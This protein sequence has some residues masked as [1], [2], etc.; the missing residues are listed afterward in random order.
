M[1]NPRDDYR[2]TIIGAQPGDSVSEESDGDSGVCGTILMGLS[3]VLIIFTLPFSLCVC[4][5]VV[6]EYERAVIF[7]LGRLMSGGAKGP[8]IFFILPCI[9]AYARVDLRTR[10][11]DVP[12]QEVLTK[13][14]VTVSVD[15][16]VYYRVSNATI[17]VANVEN[18]HHST[19]LLAQ[20]TLRNT[21]GMRPLHE[22]LSDRD[23]ISSSMQI[24]LDGATDAWGIKVER[25][26]IK[27]VRLPVQLQRAMAAEAEAAREARAKVIAAEG[28]QRASRALREAAEVIGDSPAALQ[29]RY[30]QT[31]NTISAEKNSTI[32]FPLPIDLLTY[33]VKARE[34]SSK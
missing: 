29:L 4:F 2:K 3:W 17:S 20:T 27:D 25:V 30:L 7:R 1:M 16:V 26:E 13:D 22:I 19:R 8:G 31:L 24:T 15:A 18:A 11:Y 14:S 6:Q 10:T 28:E 12:P 34:A 23:T 5:K 9:D 33:F 32:V 21:L